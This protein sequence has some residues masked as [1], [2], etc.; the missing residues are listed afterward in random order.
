MDNV[1][2]QASGAILSK[3]TLKGSPFFKKQPGNMLH[4]YSLVCVMV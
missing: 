4:E 2:F 3:V 1:Y